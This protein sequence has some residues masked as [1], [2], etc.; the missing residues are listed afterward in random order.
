MWSCE[1]RESVGVV[2][3]GKVWSCE[4]REKESRV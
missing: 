3:G 1:G 4:G 2:R